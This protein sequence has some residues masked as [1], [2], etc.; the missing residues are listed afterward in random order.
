MNLALALASLLFIYPFLVYPLL[1]RLVPIRRRPRPSAEHIPELAMVICALNE[2]RIIG[3][4]L[5]NTFELDYP[6]DK[7]TV[8]FVNDGS[9]DRT[10]DI[11]KEF[12]SRGL[13]VIDRP[14]RLGKVANLNAVIPTLRQEYV[15]LSDA[16][17]I[18]DRQALR[19]LTAPFADPQVGCVSGKVVLV[20]T[21][22]SLRQSEGLYYSIEWLLQQKGSDLYSMCGADG[23]MYVFRRSLFRPC[24]P[25]TLIED[26]VLPM[27][28]VRQGYRTLFEARALGWEHGPTSLTEEYRR[29]VRIAAGST[30]A[31][32]RRNGVPRNAPASFW[33]IWVS[34]KLMRWLSPLFGLAMIAVAVAALPSP[35]AQAILGFWLLVT[36]L[37]FIR[38]LTGLSSPVLNVPFYFVFSQIAMAIGLWRGLTGSQSVLWQKANR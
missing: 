11:A 36:A 12:V 10:L 9:T 30:Q 35:A 20:D 5:T 34:H 6:P 31:L 38:W 15:V 29:K 13:V 16:N 22:A 32:L 23:A 33:F 25:D 21:T 18:Y 28:I 4:K 24:P 17:V 14:Q 1:M 19:H 37:A 2:E 26:F 7:L 27:Q 8:Y 3:E